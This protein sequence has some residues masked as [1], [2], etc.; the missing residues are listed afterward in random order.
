MVM[1]TLPSTAPNSQ[2]GGG[3]GESETGKGI[4]SSAPTRPASQ[5]EMMQQKERGRETGKERGGFQPGWDSMPN[6]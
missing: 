3:P 6:L 5:K 2:N 1:R 4:L